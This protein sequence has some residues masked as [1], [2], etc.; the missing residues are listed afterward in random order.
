MAKTSIKRIHFMGIGGSAISGVAVMAKDYG[1]EVSGCNLEEKT[2][3]IEKVKK[4]GIK[5]FAGHSAEHLKNIDLIVA[6]PSIFYQ[7][8]KND[9]FLEA[10]NNKKLV[11]WDEFFG[12]YILKD[13]V[14]VCVAGTHGKSTT[15]ALCGLV[16]E[17][18]GL[19]PNVLVGA[20][21]K[22]WQANERLGKGNTFVIEADEFYEKYLHYKPQ[23]IILNNIEFD[24]PDYFSNFSE[25]LKSFSK[26]VSNLQGKKT[27][28]VN[29][30]SRGVADLFE[31][32]DKDLLKEIDIYGYTLSKKPKIKLKKS[33]H[34]T[35]ASQNE[36]FTEF[37]V[38]SKDLDMNTNFRL[39]IPGV[40]NVQNA[41]G[42]ITLAK[43]FGINNDVI[44]D[45]LVNFNGIGRRLENLGTKR[46]IIVFDDYA[47]HPTAIKVTIDAL[48]QKYPSNR[49][50]V[51][52]EPH[53]FSRTKAL[54]EEYKDTFE[55]A[56][57][58]V[59]APIFQARDTQNF[60]VS[61]QSV[62]DVIDDPKA[63]YLDTFEKIVNLVK[64]DVKEG[65]VILVMGA[66][67]SYE[68][69]RMILEKL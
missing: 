29:Q 19:D 10:R 27:L 49:L 43:L 32:I 20:T 31:I 2:P 48:K 11:V 58:V 34:A 44:F 59:I 7:N 41:L 57:K 39:S 6:S 4:N 56:D 26:F 66:G 40:Y 52:N 47:H 37:Q 14:S 65:D 3:Y 42:V 51:I 67:K 61:G 28:I 60:G 46:G 9:E 22:E 1:F 62:V 45:S 30:D 55:K 63:I 68:L 50:W 23:Y 33:I 25:V 17:K 64:E 38:A 53:S 16:L 13:K 15:T 12:E 69:S 36:D 8:A 35:I 24:H 21:V 5:V 18:A 54:L